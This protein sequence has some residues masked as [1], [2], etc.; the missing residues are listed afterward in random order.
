MII[1]QKVKILEIKYFSYRNDR[2]NYVEMF[3]KIRLLRQK[4]DSLTNFFLQDLILEKLK[5]L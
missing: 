1:L 2:S 3:F 5:R 4:D